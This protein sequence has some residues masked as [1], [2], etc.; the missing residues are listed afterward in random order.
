MRQSPKQ[1]KKT[2]WPT[3]TM[4]E[5][6]TR[7]SP[8]IEREIDNCGDTSN[9]KQKRRKAKEE[10]AYEPELNINLKLVSDLITVIL[11]TT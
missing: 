10:R 7:E 8:A 3:V 5:K 6:R 9:P 2:K 4:P 1:F 11:K